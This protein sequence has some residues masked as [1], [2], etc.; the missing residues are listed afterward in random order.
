MS[1]RSRPGLW[2]RD[3]CLVLC[4]LGLC[5][6][7][8]C[9]LGFRGRHR[10]LG[11]CGRLVSLGL[12]GPFRSLGPSWCAVPWGGRN[13]VYS[14]VHHGA[15][16]RDGDYG[17]RLCVC[18]AGRDG[19]WLRDP[20]GR[21]RPAAVTR[22]AARQRDRRRFM[23]AVLGVWPSVILSLSLS[24]GLH[25]RTHAFQEGLR[26]LRPCYPRRR[27][28]A[29]TRTS[30]PL[31]QPCRAH[32]GRCL[33]GWCFAG[34]CLGGWCFAGPR[35]GRRRF[36]GWCL[37]GLPRKG[38][39]PV[40]WPARGRWLVIELRRLGR[41]RGTHALQERLRQNRPCY[42]R[43]RVRPVARPPH[44]PRQGS[45]GLE[46]GCLLITPLLWCDI[47]LGMAAL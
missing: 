13:P 7:G 38:R 23:P 44:S 28:R 17:D 4:R 45:R 22:I 18:I 21:L 46:G 12:R 47:R 14:R 41:G 36:A 30:Y 37:G 8:L 9:C 19:L 5:R 16:R 3:C 6:L 31:R 20:C 32:G 26:Q 35:L 11:L 2:R 27:P 40:N 34:G 25:R 1:G 24:V 15:A 10:R 33:G 39:R 29:V 43:G 42:P